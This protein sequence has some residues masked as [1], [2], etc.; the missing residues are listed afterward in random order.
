MRL[1]PFA[2]AGAGVSAAFVGCCGAG[3]AAWAGCPAFGGTVLGVSA[4]GCGACFGAGC[5]G[6]ALYPFNAAASSPSERSTAIG[7][8]TAT[9]S[10]PSG[11]MILP[12]VPS[13]TASTSI[14]ALSVSISAMGSPEATLSPSFFSHFESLPCSMVGDSAGMRIGVGMRLSLRKRRQV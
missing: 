4:C 13:S 12:M 2:F 7:V 5:A 3:F 11:I 6:S 8:F 14:V 10:V 1:W 9:P